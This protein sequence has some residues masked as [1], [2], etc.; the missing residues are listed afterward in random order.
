MTLIERYYSC[1][2]VVVPRPIGDV[3]VPAVTLEPMLAPEYAQR[4]AG[5]DVSY[6][7]AATEADWATFDTL[8]PNQDAQT[9]SP[10]RRRLPRSAYSFVDFGGDAT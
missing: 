6:L 2:L 7:V 10:Y 9:G 8:Y 5:G 4:D 3:L 1:A